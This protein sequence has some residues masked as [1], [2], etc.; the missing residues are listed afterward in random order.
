[1]K[2]PDTF[3]SFD[4]ETTGLD[5]HFHEIIEIGAV[6]VENGKIISEYSEL[7]KPEKSIPEFIVH[8]TGI[9]NSDVK[10]SGSIH[11]VIPSF[12]DF[13]RGYTLLGQN[14]SFDISFLRNYAGS[15]NIGCAI[16][17]IE[18][19]RIILPQLPSYSLDSLIEFFSITPENRH[20]ALYDARIT[21]IIFLRLIDMLRMASTEFAN[22]MLRIS[23][24]T[25][26]D[27]KEVFEAHIK[28]RIAVSSK[29][30][31]KIKSVLTA[32]IPISNNIIGDFTGERVHSEP[33]GVVIDPEY[34]SSL[35]KKGGALSEHHLAYEE[36][37]GQIDLA[38]KIATAFN[39]SEI[40][41]A[42][43][44]TGIGKSIAYLIPAVLWAEAAQER[45]VISTNTKNLQEQLFLKDIPLLSKFLGFP[46]RAVI[47]K[48][49]GNYIC[50]NRWQRIID[51][52]ERYL[53][54]EE[55]GLLLPVASWLNHTL[56]GDLSETGFY[57]ML[58]ESGLLESIN[59]DSPICLGSRCKFHDRCFVNRVRKAAQLSHVIIVNHSLVFSDMVSDG[60]VL[61][62]Y[63]RIVF[64]EAHNIEKVALRFL[65]VTLNYYRISR[66]LN[67]L[68]SGN[69]GKY[70]LL[71]MLDVWIDKMI[72]GWPE[73]SSN[74]STIESAINA[75]RDVHSSAKK[76]FES[77]YYSVREDA[78]N[79][80]N[81]HEGKLRYF[82][83]CTVFSSCREEIVI[84]RESLSLLIGVLGDITTLL[85]SV[86][87]NQLDRKEELMIEIEEHKIDSQ[88]II[89]D[90]DFLVEAAGQ[91]VFWFEYN[92]NGTLY[93][94]KI[95]SAPL[96]IAEKLAFGL[97]DHMETVIMTS[98]TLSVA[99]DFS[100][101]KNR[102]GLNLD[103]RDRV[104]EFIAASPFDYKAQS[105]VII[106]SFLHSPKEDD[107]I[108]DTNDVLFSLAHD[109]NRGM[110][111][112]F[113]SLSHLQ[114]S[115]YELKDKFTHS[116]ITLLAQGIDGSRNNILRRF[117]KETLSVLFGTDSFWEG[118]DVPGNALELV[119]IIRLPFA[120]PTDPVIQAQMEEVEKAGGDPFMDFSV[121]EAA[122]KL[123]QGA[124]RLIRHRKDIG[125]VI[126]LDK[127][128]ITTHYG[129]LFR[130]SLPGTTIKAENSKML[131]KSLNKWFNRNIK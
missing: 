3:V 49:R 126:I 59:S 90:I 81:G 71:A 53:S 127:R 20:R 110:L 17:N 10:D 114:Q 87:S 54:K 104:V 91:N 131:I 9:S 19:A 46:F 69:E 11:E 101:I 55:R 122:I 72:K 37:Q 93:S 48:G 85:S 47:L 77:L 96:D 15:E 8:L 100:Y 31:E 65:G 79:V 7:V 29:K 12:F 86:S 117:Q 60:G 23:F 38:E 120:V 18:F 68:F 73:F 130:K 121:P 75:V 124:G 66:V 39:E 42:E 24:R 14:V 112:L 45:V 41:L 99:N 92:E 67:H 108:Q 119:V 111:V 16:D 28:E 64:D 83:N 95:K 98:A 118:V 76:L 84:F 50:L 80:E 51:T 94:F 103:T 115:Y 88:S 56:T 40:L 22:E 2:T 97:Y 62:S 35:L 74:K 109:V 13:A 129:Y 70:G 6:K 21:A 128:I 57:S 63:N 27:I 89:D 58:I 43:A 25:G 26:S 113:T 61:G 125:V 34:I 78:E 105:A 30:P 44:G 123:R 52:P 33:C 36:R 82:N 106:P 102:L 107:F 32:D 5:P 116:G 4:I 1:M